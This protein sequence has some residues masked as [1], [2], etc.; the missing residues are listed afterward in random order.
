M[1]RGWFKESY[2]HRL[3]AKGISTRRYMAGPMKLASRI[4]AEPKTK[5]NIGEIFGSG[6]K[7]EIAKTLDRRFKLDD[8]TRAK[9]VNLTQTQVERARREQE[10]RQRTARTTFSGEFDVNPS[11]E[12]VKELRRKEEQ[13]EGLT[14]GE[15][16]TLQAATTREAAT[17]RKI[18]APSLS[19]LA[20]QKRDIEYH[21]QLA[22]SNYERR[23]NELQS[24]LM[25][26]TDLAVV[27]DK[28]SSL[29]GAERNLRLVD[30]ALNKIQQD[31]FEFRT[32][33]TQPEL[34]FLLS[35]EEA[36][37]VVGIAQRGGL[38]D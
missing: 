35:S 16:L 12:K 21:L 23:V 4:G 17:E 1:T 6:P 13:G 34:N 38:I 18:S 28:Q 32:A 25:N 22:K 33:R 37:F 8:E 20:D 7:G 29:E 2:R 36:G 14:E 15:M 5:V 24:Q 26:T 3:S 10:G 19:K 31:G 11:S 30:S 9:R 27:E